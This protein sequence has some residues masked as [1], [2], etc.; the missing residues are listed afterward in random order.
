LPLDD[1]LAIHA[2]LRDEFA[3]TDDAVEPPGVKDENALERAVTRAQTAQRIYSS[4]L[5]AGAAL[6]H[7]LNC[8]H[9]FHNGNKRTSL[10]ALAIFLEE[11]NGRYLKASEDDLYEMIV[12]I[13]SHTLVSDR[14]SPGREHDPYYS[15]RELLEVHRRLRGMVEVPTRRDVRL[16]WHELVRILE[17]FGCEVGPLQSNQAKIRRVREDGRTL[18]V[19]AGARNPGAEIGADQVRQYRKKLELTDEFGVDSG[20]FYG[21]SEPHPDLPDLVK[22]Y[23]GVLERLSLL[24]RTAPEQQPPR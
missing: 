20:I 17:Q 16:K 11:R 24:D 15:D 19:V 12:G 4:V 14:D 22:R 23:R 18:T 21:G 5:L 9:A 1:V 3:G 10:L 6:V 2:A 7:S 13:A 8:N